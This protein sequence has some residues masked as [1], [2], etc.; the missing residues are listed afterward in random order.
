MKIKKSELLRSL[1]ADWKNSD[2]MQKE[3]KV[4]REGWISETMGMPYG[5]EDEN[6]SSIVSKDI[7]KQLEW[8]IPTITDPF[9]SSPD[10]I[11]CNP[12]TF[13][14][15][16]SARQNELLLN[17]Q[18]CRKFPRYNFINK[19]CRVLATEGTVV[20]QTG[21]DYEDEEVEVES[22]V[23]AV[24]ENGVEYIDIA[25][26]TE[27]KVLTNQPTASVCRNEDIFL[28]PT[29]MD[30]IDKCQFIIHRYETDLST[31]EAD[32]RFK[33]LD[34]IKASEGD[35]SHDVDFIQEDITKFRFEDEARKK[36]L[37][38]EYW[39][40]YDM[41]GDGLVE[42]IV[43]AWVGDTI[44]RL[45]ENPYPDKKPPFI[46]VPFNSVPFQ[47]FGEALAE[48]IGDNQKV[49]TAIT[50]GMINN[51][52]KSNNGQIGMK[53]GALDMRNRKKFLQGKNFEFNGTPADFWQG[54][55]NQIPGSAFDMLNLMNNEIESQ[56]GTKSF[57]GGING[58][59]LGN[60]ATAARGAMDA[61]AVR[62]LHLVRNIAENM[63][64]PLMRKW[65]SYNNEFLEEEEVVRVTNAEFVPIRRD[66]LGGK[67]DIEVSI[68][69]AEDNSAK[70]QQL[71]FLL[72]T[73]GNT[74]PF[75]MTK[76]IMAEIARLSRMPDLEKQLKEF[77]PPQDPAQ[78]QMKQLEMQRMQLENQLTQASI[79]DKYARAGENEIDAE[80][81]K[82]K[83][84]V[85]AAKARKLGSDADLSDIRYLKED[86]GMTH[87]ERLEIEEF[88]RKV[89]LEQLALQAAQG[90]D[91]LGV[92]Q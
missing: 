33:N 87:K 78:E 46:I 6:E 84:A 86:T 50:R 76:L 42:P 67:I 52:A 65:M 69:T 45:E 12:V 68:S 82:A 59:A 55:Y 49:K 92:I 60:T 17:T 26:T 51:M 74:V 89:N 8:M 15:T 21:W 29:C 57:S 34:K 39:G 9:L 1:K 56:T 19:A 16:P 90:D 41:D 14:D 5:N 35:A 47:M 28:D 7:K 37:V 43:C 22:E 58:S 36:L 63:I 79:A 44:I 10:I 71:S 66:D 53:R 13:E 54:S 77:T 30:D 2:Q 75:D 85:E 91:Q 24:D 80:L 18:F 23:V 11:K 3:W 73:L 48:N 38:Y 70:S 27:T 62:R 83:A 81:K 64:T 88:K 32:G 31:L 4:R 40:N 72:Q 25:M 61:T 20:I